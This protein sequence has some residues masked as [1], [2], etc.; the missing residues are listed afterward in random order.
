MASQ[1]SDDGKYF[2]QLS[3]DGKLRLWETDTSNF[4]QEFTPDFHLASPCTCLH[5]IQTNTTVNKV[6]M[7]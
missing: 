3:V 1:F 6:T 7:C 2:A 5:F 4:M